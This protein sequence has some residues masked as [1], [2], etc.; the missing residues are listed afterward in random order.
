MFDVDAG[1]GIIWKLPFNDGGD[2]FDS[3]SKFC[4][5]EN[6]SRAHIEQIKNFLIQ[7]SKPTPSGWIKSNE[8]E[9]IKEDLKV[10]PMTHMQFFEDGKVD[11][12]KN[13]ILK[14]N[15]SKALLSQNQLT[16]L[17]TI[18][19]VVDDRKS[20]TTSKLYKHEL[21]LLDSMIWWD[22]ENLAGPLGLFHLY[23]IHPQSSELFKVVEKGTELVYLLIQYLNHS[24][25]SP[26]VSLLVL[27]CFA[28]LFK[29]PSGETVLWERA[30]TILEALAPYSTHEKLNIR[31]AVSM[32]YLNYSISYLPITEEMDQAMIDIYTQV[33]A[34][35]SEEQDPQVF[36]RLIT[37]LSNL[38]CWNNNLRDF[39]R[40]MN[41]QIDVSWFAGTEESDLIKDYFSDIKARIK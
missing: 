3:A 10:S 17:D 21:E 9:E 35:I 28:N 31:Q 26:N 18:V 8:Q 40:T 5:R 20:Y 23:L 32:I 15:E 25:I 2:Y 6:F 37:A 13:A 1:D 16:L 24:K 39:A 34:R 19:K 30:T 38:I 11:P 29:F 22:V 12:I 27:W 4:A 33:S 14:L 7:N 36:L 41:L